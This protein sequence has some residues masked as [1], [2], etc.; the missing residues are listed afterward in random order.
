MK[1]VAQAVKS[2]PRRV[3]EEI[4]EIS[5]DSSN[6]KLKDL[7]E[8]TTSERKHVALYPGDYANS[9][10][11]DSS[12]EIVIP[13]NVSI[14]LMPGAIVDYSTDF[15]VQEYD[16]SGPVQEAENQSGDLIHPLADDPTDSDPPDAVRYDAP[17]FK[18]HVENIADLNLASEW[19]FKQEFERSLWSVRDDDSATVLQNIPFE[20]VLEFQPEEK[21]DLTVRDFTPAEGDEGGVVE[22]AHEPTTTGPGIANS[23]QQVIQSISVD[24]TG[25]VLDAT[26]VT[27]ALNAVGGDVVSVTTNAQNETIINHD[28]IPVSGSPANS[29]T[30]VIQS[31]G[32]FAPETGHIDS[33]TSVDI[34]GGS[35]INVF[36]NGTAIEVETSFT[37]EGSKPSDTQGEN[38]DVALIVDNP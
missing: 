21:I 19:A 10:Y 4:F 24:S 38:G 17:N 13:K 35:N 11:S 25:H 2:E 31:L 28:S 29:G 14:T 33:V 20:G 37:I 26:A 7:I 6:P 1:V 18:G 15:R 36:N 3:E 12:I 16:Y 9:I 23:G 8:D 32:I 5:T 22:I 27:A 30:S 34:A